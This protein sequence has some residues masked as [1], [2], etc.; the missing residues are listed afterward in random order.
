MLYLDYAKPMDNGF[1]LNFF[2]DSADDIKEVSEGKEFIASSGVNY[3]AP[4]SGSTV[5]ITSPD[6]TK[7][8]YIL[9]DSGFWSKG[10]DN[11]IAKMVMGEMIDITA[12]DLRGVTDYSYDASLLKTYEKIGSVEFPS[13]AEIENLSGANMRSI[14]IP[15]DA[16]GVAIQSF[17]GCNN[18]EQVEWNIEVNNFDDDA[19]GFY[20]D[21]CKKLKTI[22]YGEK[23]R[24]IA[25]AACEGVTSLTRV[26]IK[27][28][29]IFHPYFIGGTAFSGC[30]NLT[31]LT[32]PK[33][34]KVI[35]E[36]ALWLGSPTNKATITFLDDK[37]VPML[38]NDPFLA[39]NLNK[40]I[41]PAG[42]GEMYKSAPI[43]SNYADFIEEA[44][45]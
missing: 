17:S 26:I 43:W 5:V 18:L 13:G 23:V 16:R 37:N 28:H 42:C 12:E 33:N 40:I 44:A 2:A 35:E 9:D 29:D 27:P 41:V 38:D 31:Q 39:E 32:L 20:F 7:E 6:K 19:G 10:K 36:N 22:I 4:L 30:E 45:E 24:K 8:T 3:G 15:F 21:E 14:I 34:L 25:R 11:K 1:I